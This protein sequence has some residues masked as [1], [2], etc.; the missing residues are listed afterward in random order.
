MPET[1][2]RSQIVLGPWWWQKIGMC[3]VA[4]YDIMWHVGV[5]KLTYWF[6]IRLLLSTPPHPTLPR[7]LIISHCRRWICEPVRAC[8]KKSSVRCRWKRI[9]HLWSIAVESKLRAP[10]SCYGRHYTAWYTH[11]CTCS[12]RGTVTSPTWPRIFRGWEYWRKGWCFVFFFFFLIPFRY[13]DI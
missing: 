4:W 13:F 1:S 7:L 2:D 3:E 6:K 5:D 11:T 10:C 8:L 12:V 9:N